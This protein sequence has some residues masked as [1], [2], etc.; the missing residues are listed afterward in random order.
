M[1][2]L[3]NGALMAACFVAA[4]IFLRSWRRTT[5]RLFVY[6]AAAFAVMGLE[7]LILGVI[8]VPETGTPTVYL[9]RLTAFVLILIGIVD[10]NRS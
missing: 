3:L 10:K 7:R 1:Y 6:F 9:L 8:N 4:L 5:D 2:P